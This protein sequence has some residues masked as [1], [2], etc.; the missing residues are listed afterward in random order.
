MS[1]ADCWRRFCVLTECHPDMCWHLS[2]NGN[3]YYFRCL[4]PVSY[5]RFSD[6][7]I[8]LSDCYPLVGFPGYRCSV[9]TL[10]GLK[11]KLTELERMTNWE[12]FDS[13]AHNARLSRLS[14]E[15]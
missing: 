11:R 14:L 1:Y 15:A 2:R 3:T 13:L 12:K 5:S 9:Y 10:T 7:R 4:C 8:Y 6:N